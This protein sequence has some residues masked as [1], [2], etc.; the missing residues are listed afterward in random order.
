[1]NMDFINLVYSEIMNTT[2]TADYEYGLSLT[3]LKPSADKLVK[4]CICTKLGACI[5]L[6]V[7]M[8]VTSCY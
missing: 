3:W 7:R 1:M 2:V 8:Y 5:V 6:S 4:P